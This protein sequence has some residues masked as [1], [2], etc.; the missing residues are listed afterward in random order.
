MTG[1]HH[2][3]VIKKTYAPGTKS[4]HEAVMLDTEDGVLLLRRQGGNPF[5]DTVL[6][7]LVGKRA[8]FS[9]IIRGHTLIVSDWSVD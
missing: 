7:E 9:G 1:R 8:T 6:E 4:E 5:A 3:L 2:G